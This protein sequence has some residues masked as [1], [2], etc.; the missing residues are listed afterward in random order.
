MFG[1]HLIDIQTLLQ[2]SRGIPHNSLIYHVPLCLDS[3]F[4]VPFFYLITQ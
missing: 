4:Q 3:I 1:V 2:F